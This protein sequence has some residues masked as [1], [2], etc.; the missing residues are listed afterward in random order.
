MEFYFIPSFTGHS[1]AVSLAQLSACS[2]LT[3]QW[4]LISVCVF[5]ASVPAWPRFV[6]VRHRDDA[7]RVWAQWRHPWQILCTIWCWCSPSSWCTDV[8]YDD[9][10]YEPNGTS[11]HNTTT[12][13]VTGGP[14]S[15]SFDIGTKCWLLLTFVAFYEWI[16]L[17]H[18]TS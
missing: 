16:F 13:L 8:P 7:G 15:P 5:V 9:R 2:Y 12:I 3:N 11:A 17:P 6:L 18:L 1:S 10:P 14:F 4:L